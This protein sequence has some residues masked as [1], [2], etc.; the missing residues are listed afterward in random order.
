MDMDNDI[1]TDNVNS[2]KI[3]DLIHDR[4]LLID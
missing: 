3:Y 4:D 1:D 2:Q